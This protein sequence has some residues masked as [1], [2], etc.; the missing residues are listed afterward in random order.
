MPG[1]LLVAQLG[2]SVGWPDLQEPLAELRLLA[3]RLR[4]LS[5]Q[6]VLQVDGL[7]LWRLPQ[8]CGS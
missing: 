5:P 6:L 2:V 3:S 4:V 8:T 1:S 7:R